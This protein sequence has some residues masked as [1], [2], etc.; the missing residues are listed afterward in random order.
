MVPMWAWADPPYRGGAVATEHPL[1]S[2]AARAVMD[3]GGN[4]FDA[5]VAAAFVLAVVAPYHS[6]LGGGGFALTY[7][8]KA[9]HAEVLD[10]REVAPKSATRDMYLKDGQVVA[11]KSTDGPDS[12]A[13]PGAVKGYLELLAKHG[14]LK[15]ARVLAP[16]I[17]LARDGFVVT[18]NFRRIADVRAACLSSDPDAKRLFLDAPL[19]ATVKQPELAATLEKLARDGARAFYGKG[20]IAKAIAAKSKV[21]L[22]DLAAFTTRVREPLAGTY[23]G[24]RILTMPPPS[25]GGLA[26]LQTLGVMERSGPEGIA[27]RSV[28]AVHTYV[29]ALARAYSDRAKYLGDPAVVDIPL[30][31][32]SGAAYLDELK[33]A[34]PAKHVPVSTPAA[35][36]AQ[37]KHTTH[38]SVVDSEGNAA[39]ITTTVNYLFGACVM[40]AGVV[41][42][43]CM[44]DFA[45]QPGEK[46]VYGLVTGEGNAIAPGKIPLSSM[47]PTLVFQEG[48]P[49][50]VMLVLGAAGGPTIP[51]S[52]IQTI[53]NVIDGHL[54]L[55]RALARPRVHHQ[56]L[57][58]QV[59]LEPL[60]LEPGTRAGLEAL[61]HKFREVEKWGDCEAVMVD[62][63]NG[64]RTASGDPRGEGA[65]AGQP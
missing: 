30:A 52:V 24:H 19:G 17:K 57:P 15:P 16:A 48:R 51:T 10:F 58:D 3:Q 29:E 22:E 27:L 18:P 36:P 59:D 65:G 50:E 37:Q 6:G 42:N 20:P 31:K 47:S 33:A 53:S 28:A 32:L 61:G 40:A 14:R 43:D 54:S 8:A 7:Q 39:A 49:D 62:P 41:L 38:L 13:V 35:A 21:T 63:V 60:A 34:V 12:V 23:R 55:A 25:A 44:D 56:W 5:A 46:N 4:A 45:M 2:D 11:L 1:A 9:K 64:V 26:V